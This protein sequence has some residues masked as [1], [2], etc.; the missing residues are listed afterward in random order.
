MSRPIRV[1]GAAKR[2]MFE[3]FSASLENLKLSDGKFRFEKTFAATDKKAVVNL[4]PEAYRKTLLLLSEFSSEAGWHGTAERLAENEFLIEDIFVY[5]QEV[6]GV[7]VE[8]DQ[9]AYQEWLYAH[10]DEIFSKLKM[11]GHSHVN[12]GVSPSVTDKAHCENILAGLDDDEFYIFMVWNKSHTVH[13]LVYDLENNVL[14]ED[15][16]V[17]VRTYMED[18]LE[19]FLAGAKAMIQKKQPVSAA[20]PVKV[21]GR[22]SAGYYDD[23]FG[24]DPQFFYGGMEID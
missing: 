18:G 5:P 12:I 23:P 10:G 17:T 11:H 13:A 9:K 6:T 7:T 4:S 19:E 1:D 2:E 20:K 22:K 16:D 24:Y 8:T 3:A 21:K 14:Y 15:K